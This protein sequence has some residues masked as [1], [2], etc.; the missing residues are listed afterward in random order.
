MARYILDTNI[1]VFLSSG[2]RDEISS[3]VQDII[4]DYSNQLYVSAVSIMEM[5]PLFRIKK[6]RPKKYKTADSLLKA[7]ERD[8]NIQILPFGKENAAQLAK[9]HVIPNHNDP[10]DH[11]II[12][13]A[14]SQ[15]FTL[16]SSDSKFNQYEDQKLDFVR[17]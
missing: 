15:K 3:V 11:A 2:D 9:L 6:I 12:A 4:S 1:I 14:I 5:L 8:F 7:I 16:V 10:F 17:N 13:H